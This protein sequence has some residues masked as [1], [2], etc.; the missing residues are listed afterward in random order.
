[1]YFRLTPRRL[2]K[3]PSRKAENS[4]RGCA[5]LTNLEGIP[6]KFKPSFPQLELG[7]FLEF[8][9]TKRRND[10]G[11]SDNKGGVTYAAATGD[12]LKRR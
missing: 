3:C 9:E 11:G 10:E 12:Y 5:A 6:R 7:S 2:C 8:A 1:M 4:G